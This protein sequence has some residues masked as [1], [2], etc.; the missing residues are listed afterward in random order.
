MKDRHRRWH[1]AP[2]KRK[3]AL[4]QELAQADRPAS[5]T[6]LVLVSATA[7]LRVLDNA[8]ADAE[9]AGKGATLF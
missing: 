2:V 4:D 8:A 6:G 3:N 1:V 9:C 5:I 7:E